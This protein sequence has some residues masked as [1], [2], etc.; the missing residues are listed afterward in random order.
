MLLKN[1]KYK[2]YN[3]QY[4]TQVKSEKSAQA[5]TNIYRKSGVESNKK[6]SLCI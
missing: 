4:T 5:L 3:K 1:N 2:K 6:S